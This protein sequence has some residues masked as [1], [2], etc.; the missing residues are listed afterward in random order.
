MVLCVV[1][2]SV[3]GYSARLDRIAA[4]STIQ[5]GRKTEGRERCPTPLA[6]DATTHRRVRAFNR[7]WRA[8]AAS[9]A[10]REWLSRV[11][12]EVEEL[13]Y[14]V[15]AA[16]LCAAGIGAPHIRQR[17]FWVGDSL[18]E[19][20]E[21]PSEPD[22]SSLS[23]KKVPRRTDVDRSSDVG[24]VGKPEGI[25]DGEVPISREHREEPQER[26]IGECGRSGSSDAWSRF[27]LV[28][29]ADG[30]S[31][32]VEAGTFPLAHGVPGRVGLLRGYG[33]AIVPQLA[34]EFIRAWEG[35]R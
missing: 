16:D 31:R 20:L 19:R 15:G 13:G 35:V 9:K 25:R 28:N 18:H 26:R 11:R 5:H 33:N 6:R 24:G 10:G 4:V 21:E 29:C 2:R 14:A 12:S 3:A 27:D 30:K 22:C 34:A 7:L 8:S 1:A 23:R 32:R 17:L